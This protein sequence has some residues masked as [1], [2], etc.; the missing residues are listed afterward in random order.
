MSGTLAKLSIVLRRSYSSKID[1]SYMTHHSAL[2]WGKVAMNTMAIVNTLALV[3]GRS[4][5]YMLADHS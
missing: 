2:L 1:L 4:I 5:D 3:N